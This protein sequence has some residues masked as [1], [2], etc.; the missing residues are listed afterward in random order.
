KLLAKDPAD[1]FA[2]GEEVVAALDGAPVAPVAPL[3]TPPRP[4]TVGVNY[5]D[6][7]TRVREETLA[8]VRTRLD[9]RFERRRS[10]LE[11]RD[12]KKE[13]ERSPAGR[14][15]SFR[16]HLT[17]WVGTSLFLFGINYLT[18]HDFWW[19]FFPAGGMALGVAMNFGRLWADGIPLKS[20][21][22]GLPP[23][24]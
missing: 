18:G 19:A 5:V 17:S 21:F 15:R 12:R 10:R 7:E 20:I 8:R 14:L 24:T 22:T 4:N 13:A 2:T 11:S 16:A 23:A 1:R 3:R 9:E 6:F